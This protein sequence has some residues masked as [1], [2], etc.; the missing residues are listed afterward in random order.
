M[1][2]DYAYSILKNHRLDIMP[3]SLKKDKRSPGDYELMFRIV[4]CARQFYDI[5]LI[6]VHSGLSIITAWIY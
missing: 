2:P 4:E 6:D 3:G 5:V 1:V